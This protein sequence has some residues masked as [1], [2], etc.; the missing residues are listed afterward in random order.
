MEPPVEAWNS[1]C[2][3]ILLQL[4]PPPDLVD[5]DA[6]DVQL[7]GDFR[8]REPLLQHLNDQRHVLL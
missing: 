2:C 5:G 3:L 8:R 4:I 7:F 6:F 1:W